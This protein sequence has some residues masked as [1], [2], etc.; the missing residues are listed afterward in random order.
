MN[1]VKKRLFY[2]SLAVVVALSGLTSGCGSDSVVAPVADPAPTT[3][4]AV[5]TA[6]AV[7][8]TTATLLYTS[9][10]H[11][12]IKRASTPFNY[13]FKGYSNA[14]QVNSAMVTVMNTMPSKTIPGDG[15]V[16]AGS[17]IGSIDYVVQGGDIAN[18]M[19]NDPKNGYS[20]YVQ[21]AYDSWKQFEAGFINT[22]RFPVLLFPG[23]HDVSNAIGYVKTMSRD[24]GVTPV[25]AGGLTNLDGSVM[26][27]IYN[28]F[29]R[30]GTFDTSSKTAAQNSY[31]NAT[32]QTASNKVYYS[33]DIVGVHFMF[34][35][36][37][38]DLD[39]QAW[40]EADLAKI[41]STTPAII[42]THDEPTTENK[43]LT[44][45]GGPTVFS[46]TN[47]FENLLVNVSEYDTT[48]LGIT[49][50]GVLA[51][52]TTVPYHTQGNMSTRAAQRTFVRFLQRHKNIVAYF[53]GNTNFNE[54]YTYTGP[55]NLIS[56]P[57]FRV[58][59]PMKGY[60]SGQ[61]DA[62]A[63]VPLAGA[64]YNTNLLSYHVISIDSVT[65][66]MTVREYLWNTNSWGAK[67][68]DVDLT[69]RAL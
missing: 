54:F 1:V 35:S 67:A 62:T 34:I 47:K 45:K 37:W 7:P 29:V 38:P 30:A 60:Y 17:V 55:D 12:G 68:T 49:A 56:L 10:A 57:V 13:T 3:V 52:T 44:D 4:A 58:D 32:Y 15:G 63:A 20:N 64:G 23:N 25:A 43:H 28:M 50:D 14:Q 61:D 48:A 8:A 59:S 69:P 65:K 26:A 36:M 2:S 42:F 51:T 33:K 46:T 24:G 21:S 31:T 39:A 40:M 53:H 41:S 6:P 11:Y 5:V 9:D 16:K 27:F 19:Q 18:R 22:L 66:K